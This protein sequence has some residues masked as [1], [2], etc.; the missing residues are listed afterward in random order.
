M[1]GSL[2]FWDYQTWSFVIVLSVLSGGMLL[3][4]LLRMLIR[5]LRRSLIPSAV[6]AGF[7]VLAAMK[8]FEAIFGHPMFNTSVLETLTYHG[9]GIGFV[10]VALRNTENHAGKKARIDI[11]NSG[12][13]TVTTYL[14]QA[15]VGLAI[16]VG[17]SFLIGNWA[18]GGIL[19]PMGYGQGPGQAFNWGHTYETATAYPAFQGGASF[20]LTIAAMGFIA[21][22]L[23]GVIYLNRMRRAGNPKAQRENAEELEDL[24]AEKIT[25]RDEIP[26]SESMDKFTVQVAMVLLVYLITF[27]FMWAV[28]LGLDSLGGFWVNTVKPLIWGFNFLFGTVF[29]VIIKA[30]FSG[31]RKRGWCRRQYLNN[32]MLSRISGFMFD[33]M[34]TASIAAIDL[35]AFTHKEFIIPLLAICVAGAFITYW[36]CK[37][38]CARL[39]PEYSDEAFLAMYGML[40][41]TAST[42]VILLREIDPLFD[43]PASG[44]LIY[45]QIWAIVFGFPMLLLLGVV[46]QSMTMTWITLG[47]LVTLF[48]ATFVIMYRSVI[49]KK[50]TAAAEK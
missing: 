14:I 22:S 9:L 37:R 12:L 36:Y 4:N 1:T 23:G 21:A 3:A 34:V 45:Q 10:A 38:V 43:T 25:G 42:G 18:A 19:L 46:A 29:A 15:I 39:F 41:G 44:N 8:A 48:A 35:S 11:F 30:I 17:L 50:K 32:F 28:S 6:V 40:T 20:G 27:A 13:L 31:C 5:P 2:N 26:L 7:L 49:F 33:L 24:S 16:T 47:A